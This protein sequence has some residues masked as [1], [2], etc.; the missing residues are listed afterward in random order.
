MDIRARP[1]V[2]IAVSR[3]LPI[4]CTGDPAGKAAPPC[5]SCG[6]LLKPDVVL[7]GEPLSYDIISEAQREALLCQVMLIVG[8]SLEVMPAVDLPLLA[9]R[10]GACTILINLSPTPLDDQMDVVIRADVVKTIQRLWRG[11]A[12]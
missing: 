10:R 7:F 3:R 2:W 6:G 5:A 12:P 8:T 4:A 11:L 1:P 9:K